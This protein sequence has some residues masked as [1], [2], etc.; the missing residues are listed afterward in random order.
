MLKLKTQEFLKAHHPNGFELLKE[1]YG[2]KVSEQTLEVPGHVLVCL[3]Y[4]Q[5]ESPKTNEM[6]RECR[7][8]IL[9]KDTYEI[10]S[11][12]FRR[13][14]NYGENDETIDFKKAKILEKVD[15]SL[16]S[17]FYDEKL[18]A[19]RMSTRS[20]IDGRGNIGDQDISFHQLFVKA[21]SATKPVV[22][23]F[24]CEAYD[25][26]LIYIFELVSPYNRIVTYYSKP[27][28]YL[29]GARDKARNFMELPY[30]KLLEIANKIGVKIPKQYSVGSLEELKNFIAEN[31]EITN[32]GF[33]CVEEEYSKGVSPLADVSFKRVKVKNPAYLRL[34]H[35]K[36]DALGA[37]LKSILGCV[38]K[39]ET[40]E[41]L[42]Y[43]PELRPIIAQISTKFSMLVSNANEILPEVRLLKEELK[44]AQDKGAVRKKIAL[45]YKDSEFSDFVFSH[46]DNRCDDFRDYLSISIMKKGEDNVLKKLVEQLKLKV[47]A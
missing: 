39:G 33:V 16:V 10:V 44:N 18:Q 7:N 14:F 1:Q 13:F 6:V 15:G 12:S 4:D 34:A 21:F 43:F 29:I 9:D 22:E 46:I 30:S 24:S 38:M 27:A 40:D 2:I 5:I 36:E 25:K 41:V 20:S 45:K 35:I 37:G 28:L 23:N 19:W 32:E 8:L 26:N 31:L 11:M 47:E 17:F 3:N 42:A